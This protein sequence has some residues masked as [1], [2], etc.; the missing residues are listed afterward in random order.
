M[1]NYYNGNLIVLE[2]NYLKKKGRPIK[3]NND[4]IIK[5]EGKKN[6]YDN[7][8]V[9]YLTIDNIIKLIE[10]TKNEYHKFIYMLM[11]E[12]GGRI[13]EVREL[14]FKDIEMSGRVKIKTLKQRSKSNVFRYIKISDK[15]L[16]L[17]LNRKNVYK[18]DDDDY[19]LCKIDKKNNKKNVITEKCINESLKRNVN[20]ILTSAYIDKA[21]CHVFRH[22]KAIF[23]LD[24]GLDIV[25]LKHFLG[26]SNI[27]N[28]LIYLRYADNDFFKKLDKINEN[29]YEI[30]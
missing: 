26:H 20:L 15:M 11:F 5:Y 25:S 12:T 19:V 23:L 6:Y 1:E 7:N 21:H 10:N 22:S 27:S 16:A 9:K 3:S 13:N 29:I 24:K 4:E 17:I 2:K 18:L 28:T 8:N 14:K 30:N